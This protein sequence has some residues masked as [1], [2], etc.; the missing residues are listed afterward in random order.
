MC[1]KSGDKRY[2]G[3]ASESTAIE[4][5]CHDHSM[6]YWDARDFILSQLAQV[7]I[8]GDYRAE[9]CNGPSAIILLHPFRVSYPVLAK[10][11]YGLL[12]VTLS[13]DFLTLPRFSLLAHLHQLRKSLSPECSATPH[14]GRQFKSNDKRYTGKA[15]ESTAI[16]I[17]CHDHSMLYWDARDFILSQLAQVFICA[18]YRAEPCN[19]PSTIT[20][21]CLVGL[22]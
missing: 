3:K 1:F 13:Q 17:T 21:C 19:G 16:E 11:S 5:T 10:G 15:S 18:D 14:V 22:Y 12:C 9:T 4:I 20:V 6:L 2:T 7:F 8:C